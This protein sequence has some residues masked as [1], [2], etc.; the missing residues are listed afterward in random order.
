MVIKE[1]VI[2]VQDKD[3]ETLQVFGGDHPPTDDDIEKSIAA[4]P[5]GVFAFLDT[6]YRKNEG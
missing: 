1:Y 2:T 3:G 4:C 5:T 6:V